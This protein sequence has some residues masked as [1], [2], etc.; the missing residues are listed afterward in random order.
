M[1][2]VFQAQKR[3]QRVF[4]NSSRLYLR[5]LLENAY[6]TLARIAIHTHTHMYEYMYAN[7]KEICAWHSMYI[8]IYIWHKEV[9]MTT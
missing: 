3:K 6:E 5:V 1:G 9:K 4:K 2:L 8:Y 7:S